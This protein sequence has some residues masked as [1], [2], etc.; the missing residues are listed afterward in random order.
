MKPQRLHHG[1]RVIC[2]V[3]KLGDLQSLLRRGR[4][5]IAGLRRVI[6]RLELVA[7]GFPDEGLPEA[8]QPRL[9]ALG[10]SRARLPRARQDARADRGRAK[11]AIAS[12]AASDTC[13]LSFWCRV[14]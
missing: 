5:L 4:I 13:R 14:I 10:W 2:G 7:A 3:G 1:M 11:L 12:Q 8:V 6:R 9:Q